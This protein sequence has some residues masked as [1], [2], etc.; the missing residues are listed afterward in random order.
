MFRSL[1]LVFHYCTCVQKRANFFQKKSPTLKNLHAHYELHYSIA[2][3]PHVNNSDVLINVSNIII[4]LCHQGHL[5]TR[6]CSMFDCARGR[7]VWFGEKYAVGGGN[8]PVP[9]ENGM[10]P[11]STVVGDAATS[12]DGLMAAAT[13]AGGLARAG[14]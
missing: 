4:L 11:L 2:K 14:L 12:F 10:P 8:L 1:F 5:R 9:G 13:F 3:H 6:S 7:W